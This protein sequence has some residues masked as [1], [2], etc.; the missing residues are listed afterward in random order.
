MKTSRYLSLVFVLTL[1]FALLV[2]FGVS[3]AEG[4]TPSGIVLDNCDS[5]RWS[6]THAPFISTEEKTEG[7]G[8]VGWTVAAKK[9]QFVMQN[10]FDPVNGSGMT[11]LSFDIFISD[12]DVLYGASVFQLEMTSSGKCD[13]EESGWGLGGYNLNN[14]EW[15][16]LEL[17][18]GAGCNM[19][20]VNYLRLYAL[21]L[22][23]ETDLTIMVDNIRLL[24][25]PS[26]KEQTE[27]PDGMVIG[28]EDPASAQPVLKGTQSKDDDPSGT[29][30]DQDKDKEKEAPETS[31]T[32]TVGIVLAC[33]GGVILIVLALLTI[34][35]KGSTVLCSV[36]GVAGI[37][38]LAAATVLFLLPKNGKE[39][40]PGSDPS[41]DPAKGYFTIDQ[42]GHPELSAADLDVEAILRSAEDY[43]YK[44]EYKILFS[45]DLFVTDNSAS[46]TDYPHTVMTDP[47]TSEGI[48]LT[49]FEGE[50]RIMN[51]KEKDCIILERI[52]N[53]N[54]HRF[55][56][57]FTDTVKKQY[58]GKNFDLHF[59]VYVTEKLE[60]TAA[61]RSASGED[62][63]STG[64]CAKKGMWTELVLPFTEADLKGAFDGH[65][66]DFTCGGAEYTRISMVWIT[67][68][69][70]SIAAEK[71][72][73]TGILESRFGGDS[74][75]LADANVMN[76][77]A[78]GD[79][80]TDDTAA[81]TAAIEAVG[82]KGG[83]TVFVP[84]GFYCLT[85]SLTLPSHVGLV[86]ELDPDH[87][88]ESTVL[89]VYGGK[90]SA[91]GSAAFQ[92]NMQSAVTDLAVWYP[93]QTFVN[94]KPIPYPATFRQAGSE[95]VTIR[96]VV[97][98][99]SYFG[100]DFASGGNN[101]LQYVRNVRGTCL[102]TGYENN[103]SYDIGRIEELELTPDVWLNSGLPGTPNEALLRTYM[104]RNSVGM[105]LER[106]D[107]TYLADCRMEGLYIGVLGRQ[108]SD[109][110]SN[111]HIYNFT[112]RD[113]YYGIRFDAVSWM[114]ITGCDISAAGN[115]GAAAIYLALS[116]G[117]DISVT[118][119][120]LSTAGKNAIV[121]FGSGRLSLTDSE[122]TSV[123]GTT[124]A[125]ASASEYSV[126]NTKI[127]DGGQLLY[128]FLENEDTPALPKVD[129]AKNVVTKPASDKL[130]DLTAEPYNAKSGSDIT[131][132]LQ[133]ALDDM[134]AEGG[135]LYL[136][137]GS[138]I[139][140]DHI[141]VW[142][143]IELRGADSWAQN[144]NCTGIRTEYGEGDPDGIALFD[145]YEGS[146]MRGIG[147]IYM[148]NADTKNIHNHSYTIRG[149]GKNIYLVD[150]SLPTSW[151]GVDFA[152]YRC[153]GHYIE[154]LWM[155]PLNV[156]IYVGGG[157][158]NGIIRDCHF[159][160]NTWCLRGQESY[161]GDVFYSYIMPQS[162]PY[163]VGE[164]KNEILYHNFV[165]GAYEGL[166]LLD[167]AQNVYTLCHGVDSGNISTRV[168][169]NATATMVDSQ[170]VNLNGSDSRYVITE[171]G[172][173]GSLTMINTAGW[174]TTQNAFW[175]RGNGTVVMKSGI[176]ISAG[177]PMCRM[178]GSSL[179]MYSVIN[180]T[181]TKD[182]T[183][184]NNSDSLYIAGNIFA[185]KLRIEN[186]SEIEITGPDLEYY[187]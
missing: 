58:Q 160:P 7:K 85:S 129:Y 52:W 24:P 161:W 51:V 156:G 20:H 92:M 80:M 75:I 55:Y 145:L 164:S 181:R 90:G 2:P 12:V 171:D 5:A 135:T 17:H 57:D 142:A 48:T 101:S 45:E 116:N 143:G 106:I 110:T 67:D 172:F 149:N 98:V 133:K 15:T 40:D 105:I 180:Q 50:P 21:G 128:R 83:G 167:G 70:A 182:F 81:F 4:D 34:L 179:K 61:Y 163:V 88:R 27:L 102:D 170:L 165:Y 8:A 175:F 151:N 23:P 33:A 136:P 119:C 87:L 137:A 186:P 66:L 104:I 6:G 140:S 18:I 115:E 32:K 169:G 113:C 16:H 153:D 150:V 157:S 130:V 138:Y 127:S 54:T 38:L 107:W 29:P 10:V 79:G 166:S 122:L 62:K 132:L 139:V 19:E 152:T 134:K 74:Y 141:N 53:K 95:S 69:T 65:D 125:H 131:A 158:E 41:S 43:D 60:L 73:R 118:D 63:T 112:I 30:A 3:A 91:N 174:G 22:K 1:L 25:E 159:T 162:K 114:M 126:V 39:P 36:I 93:E 76:F 120:K 146:G 185:S 82:K 46:A 68:H 56:L 78:A 177:T 72:T 103:H 176:V 64:V 42:T 187:G 148:D 184:V 35:K 86:G 84:A 173:S 71:D 168:F 44:N 97:M 154:Y 183:M 96:N 47:Q 155:C 11:V 117:G 77:G 28:K 89:C 13:V 109:G 37:L 14:N 178:N 121:N 99:N 26:A 124:L 31:G 144:Q 108:T 123:G 111:G 59:M 147:V 9:D 94:G 49:V 100:I